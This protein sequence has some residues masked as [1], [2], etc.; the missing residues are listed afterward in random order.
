MAIQTRNRN[1][2]GIRL[3]PSNPEY[4]AEQQRK[5]ANKEESVDSGEQAFQREVVSRLRRVETRLVAGMES[6][7][8]TLTNNA[9]GIEVMSHPEE[10]D[11]VGL[12]T[13]TS[14]GT[15]VK[16]L[17]EALNGE[18]GVYDISYNGKVKCQIS[19]GFDPMKV[20]L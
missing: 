15:T 1:R 4:H 13:I 18:S 8:A 19:M 12:I 10:E 6:L 17:L 2:R 5:F 7:G 9:G 20:V 11:E 3:K 14:L 16:D